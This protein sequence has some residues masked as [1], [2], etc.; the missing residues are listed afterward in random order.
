[1]LQLFSTEPQA[2]LFASTVFIPEIKGFNCK[3]FRN[4]EISLGSFVGSFSSEWDTKTL[5]TTKNKK[6]NIIGR[7]YINLVN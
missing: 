4:F 7:M 2:G 3:S 5:D 6:E 1:M